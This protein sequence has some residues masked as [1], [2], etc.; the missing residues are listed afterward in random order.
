MSFGI[1]IFYCDYP[2][3]VARPGISDEIGRIIFSCCDFRGEG[4]QGFPDVGAGSNSANN[5]DGQL[6]DK[7]VSIRSAYVK[8]VDTGNGLFIGGD[9][10]EADISEYGFAAVKQKIN[11]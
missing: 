6:V 2:Q 8:L 7:S 5:N 11:T 3:A 10:L 1:L 9:G 4:Y